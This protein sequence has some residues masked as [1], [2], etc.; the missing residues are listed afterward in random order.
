MLKTGHHKHRSSSEGNDEKAIS[1]FFPVG[2]FSLA[3]AAPESIAFMLK[4]HSVF[5][6]DGQHNLQMLNM[7]DMYWKYGVLQTFQG[8]VFN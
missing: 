6:W 5:S 7:L 1:F 3:L 4:T 8:D 2:F